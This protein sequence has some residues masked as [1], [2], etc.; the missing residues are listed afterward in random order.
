MGEHV[1]TF[2]KGMT[3]DVSVFYQPDG[4]YRYMKNCSLISQDGNNFVIKDCMGNVK[5][6]E[7]NIPYATY[8]AIGPV[9]TYSIP[10]MIIAFISF[11]DKL[12]VFST[13]DETEGGGYGE[14]GII[15][16]TNYGEGIQPIITAN[17]DNY[18]YR[19]IYH[20]E[21]L[22][23]TK[24]R[25]IEGFAYAEN[26][27]AQRVYWTDNLNQPRV[28]NVADPIYT[29]YIPSGSLVVG[30]KYMVLE[31]IIDHPIAA[32]P[33]YYAPVATASASIAGNVFT[34]SATTY[35]DIT[36]PLPKALVIEYYPIELLDF[37]PSRLLGT[38]KFK[39]YGTGSVI[40]GSK[41]YFYRL[42]DT[43]GNI[44]TSW[45]YASSPIHVGTVN[46]VTSTPTN[47]YFDFVGGG[48]TTV[49]LNSGK[50]VFITID[51][52]DQNFDR[53]QVACVEFDQSKDVPRQSTIIADSAITGASMDI[54]HNGSANF[55]DVTLGDLTV[56]PASINTCKTMTTNKNYILIG[57]IR[58]REELTDFSRVGVTITQIRHKMPVHEAEN[59]AHVSGGQFC[60]N[61]LSYDSVSPNTTVSPV[62]VDGIAPYTQWVNTVGVATYNG[63][64]YGP[65]ELA[66]D[67][68]EGVPGVYNWANTSGTAQVRPCVSKNKYTTFTGSH[69]K[70]DWIQ[71]N[72][73][74]SND[75]GDWSYKNPAVASH[76]KGL[77]SN[78][79]Y[80]YGIL[81]FDLKGNPYYVR[82]LD[83]FTT[84]TI[85]N[86]PLME[87]IQI[88]SGGDHDWYINQNGVNI[89]GITIPPSIIDKIS[90]FSIVRAERDATIM[91]QGMLMQVGSSSPTPGVGVTFPLA[92][93]GVSFVPFDSAYGDDRNQLYTYVCPDQ[94]VDEPID[95]YTIG[96]KISMSHWVKARDFFSTGKMMTSSSDGDEAMEAKYFEE[97]A[98]ESNP[99]P[100][101]N[102]KI[103]ALKN[104]TED[105]QVPDFGSGNDD[106]WNRVQFSGPSANPTD[107][108]CFGGGTP[109]LGDCQAI[110]GKRTLLEVEGNVYAYNKYLNVWYADL[111]AVQTEVDYKMMANVTVSKSSLYGGQGTSALANTFYISTGHF[112]PIN[113]SVKADVFDGAN[114]VFNDIEVYGG[115]CFAC[116]VDYGHSLYDVTLPFGGAF[117][118]HSW[119]M[120]FACQC[121]SNYDLRRGRT[122][123][124]NRMN[125]AATGVS[126]NPARL[127]GFSYNK[128]YSSEGIEFA[129]PA[130]PL[131]PFVNDLFRTRIRFAGEKFINE[132]IDSF[133]T[134]LINDKKDLSGAQGEI[135]N[136]RTKGDKTVV[137]QNAAISTVPILERQVVSGTNG[138]DT[139]IGTGGVVDRYDVISSEFGN[140]HQWS[141][142]ET[143][144]GFA[145]FD[146]RKKAFLT[147][148]FSSGIQEISQIKGLKGFFDEAFLEV[149]GY[150]SA[151]TNVLNSQTYDKTS[152][153]PLVGVGITGV[154]DPKFKTTYL[155]FKFKSRT[156]AKGQAYISRDFTIGYYHPSKMFIG[157]YDWTPAIAHNHNQT[158]FSVNDPKCK[159]QFY[160]TTMNPT[161]FAISDLVAYKNIEYICI[162]PV[163]I[164]AY[165]GT[166]TQVPDY[167]GSIYWYP[168]NQTNELWV[169]NQPKTW[170]NSPAPDYEY[171][172]FFGQ[173]VDN[174]VRFVINPQTKNPF[175]VL[176]IEQ[177]GNSENVT[178][179]YT[180]TQYDSASDVNITSVSRFYKWVYNAICSSLP[181]SSNGVRLTDDYLIVKLYKKN[182]TT[183][184]YIK[185][186]S[187]KILKYVKS[188]IEEKR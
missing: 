9:T 88:N 165:P 108:I 33:P 25:R 144:Y 32:G 86:N 14:I 4:T 68:F 184:P 172:M 121:N 148:D 76:V 102:Y 164:S 138:S 20:H 5:M 41:V 17:Q 89:S 49:T 74:A 61:I 26:D 141:V 154:Y 135:N 117:I 129:Y 180:E 30:Q 139:A 175:S 29:T 166:S 140:Q 112:Q 59:A 84:D 124:N 6:F 42:F 28:I 55:G 174:E 143:G 16:Y 35:T 60:A 51:D 97:L 93:P 78:Q 183:L 98:V 62:N 131:N 181:L 161:T 137:F 119:G 92:S 44:V 37:T 151:T 188:F 50:S 182:W 167:A 45:S 163:T 177:H 21:S 31:G 23:F 63:V 72:Q 156:Q 123:A 40:C 77:W 82:W 11:P 27:S 187:V 56:F 38:I 136:L 100:D 113:A 85:V 57:N 122:V 111:L 52:I 69:R 79:T 65:S 134:F 110:G 1:N 118:S 94:L 2:E 106:F 10:P 105:E 91:T 34:A 168:I 147:L 80:R 133:R 145:W 155:T 127:E 101:R 95:N 128:G 7:I 73:N 171:S 12:V 162:S 159:T 8:E 48:S 75:S 142:T 87:N 13:S 176:N 146:M 115:D 186:K 36:T 125:P 173:V 109:D 178:S 71:F 157:F 67:V 81:F 99:D 70:P 43:N 15:E 46:S 152:D 114:Y 132:S 19:P 3:S 22:H 120:K 103:T 149:I 158:V 107:G 160:G 39:N 18:G 66:G 126:Y 24:L 96:S 104:I 169:H 130:L 83:D 64:T 179:I 116:L 47:P 53:I 153:R 54:E 185:T 150:A 170:P 90:G 58:E